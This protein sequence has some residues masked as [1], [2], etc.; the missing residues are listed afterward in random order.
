M[1]LFTGID[2]PTDLVNRIEQ[3]LAELRPAA[4]IHWSPVGNLHLTT[5][6][7]G[8]WPEERLDEL[9]QA[10]AG[11]PTAGPVAIGVRGLGFFPNTR[12]PRVFWAGVVAPRLTALAGATEQAL[13]PLGIA[14]ENRPYSPHLTLARI[15]A[16]AP[17]HALHERIHRLASQEFGEF[18]ASRFFLYESK[19]SPAGSVYTKLS[20]FPLDK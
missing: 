1:R 18:A 3:L 11:V 2:L 4:R 5:K 17:L 9:R 10:L 13:E 15:K 14:A 12:S 8:D 16:S 20:E 7:I 6:F 19:S